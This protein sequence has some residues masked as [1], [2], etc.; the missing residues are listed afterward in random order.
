MGVM[1]AAA[2]FPEYVKARIA[3][4]LM[5]SMI[6]EEPKIDNMSEAGEKKVQ[7]ISSIIPSF[8]FFNY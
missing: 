7:K 4:G 6:R 1:T 2:Y 5:F 8:D 3:A